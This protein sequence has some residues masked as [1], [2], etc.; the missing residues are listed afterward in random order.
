MIDKLLFLRFLKFC[1][2]GFSGM[3]IDFGTTGL[4]KEKIKLNKYIANSC[5]FTLAASSNYFWNRVWTFQSQNNHIGTEYF[6]FFTISLIGLGLNNLIVWI[7]SDKWKLNFY[8]SKI[9][10]IAM[11]TFWNFGMNFFITFH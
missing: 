11:V 6:T 3:A 5:G 1:I 4:L 10:A 8:L 2:I 9:A 7:L